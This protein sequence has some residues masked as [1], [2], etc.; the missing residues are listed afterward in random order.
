MKKEQNHVAHRRCMNLK[1]IALTTISQAQKDKYHVFSRTE[2]LKKEKKG[3]KIG[4][5]Y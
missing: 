1:S 3:R 4:G 5:D 2:N